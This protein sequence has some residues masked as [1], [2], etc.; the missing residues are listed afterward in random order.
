M[1]MRFGRRDER[2]GGRR[3]VRDHD[4]LK[5]LSPKGRGDG[6]QL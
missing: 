2:T 4:G 6:I 1:K 5:H 3:E